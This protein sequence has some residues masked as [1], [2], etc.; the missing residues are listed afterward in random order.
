MYESWG[1]KCWN[2]LV[3]VMGLCLWK[4]AAEKFTD[5]SCAGRA[6]CSDTCKGRGFSLTL[7]SVMQCSASCSNT[8]SL[9]HWKLSFFPL[10][11]YLRTFFMV[12]ISLNLSLLFSV[13]FLVGIKISF[14]Q[15]NGGQDTLFGWNLLIQWFQWIIF[16]LSTVQKSATISFYAPL[17]TPSRFCHNKQPKEILSKWKLT[18]PLVPFDIKLLRQFLATLLQ[19]SVHMLQGWPVCEFWAVR[20]WWM[21]Q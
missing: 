12:Y 14:R 15:N 18:Y 16:K 10:M 1:P 11:F 7:S 5:P 3:F 20:S 21:V 8:Q 6:H 2:W 13:Y 19:S 9:R 17:V 4:A